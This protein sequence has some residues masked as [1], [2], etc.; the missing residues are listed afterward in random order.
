LFDNVFSK[1]KKDL[2]EIPDI[3]EYTKETKLKFEKQVM[4]IYLSGHPLDNF[5]EEFN[6][7]TFNASMISNREPELEEVED[8]TFETELLETEG[9]KNNDLVC[10]GGCLEEVKKIFTKVG[11]KEMAIVKVEDLFGTF[12][13]MITPAVYARNLGRV[14]EDALVKIH[15][16]VS[17]RDDKSILIIADKLDFLEDKTVKLEATKTLYL[18]YDTADGVLHANILTILKNYPGNI[19]VVVRCA[20]TNNAFKLNLLVNPNNYLINELN[21]IVDENNIKFM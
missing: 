10:C 15:G 1:T 9:I 3:K 19:P 20:S 6:K 5:M 12:E 4:G 14:V 18:K 7:F 13:V 8:E 11:N 17:I 21:A 16:K 2:V